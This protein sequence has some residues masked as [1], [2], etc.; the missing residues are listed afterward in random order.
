MIPINSFTPQIGSQIPLDCALHSWQ[1]TAC[2]F[3]L[4]L[5]MEKIILDW[6]SRWLFRDFNE[7]IETFAYFILFY[8]NIVMQV[9]LM[10]WTKFIF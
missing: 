3:T 4:E 6:K 2:D 1:G 9:K 8:P 10:L 7:F 5:Q